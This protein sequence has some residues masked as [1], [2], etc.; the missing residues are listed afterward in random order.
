MLRWIAQFTDSS[1]I[2]ARAPIAVPLNLYLCVWIAMAFFASLGLAIGILASFGDEQRGVSIA[3][4]ATA[5]LAFLFFWPAYVGGALTFL[6]GDLFLPI[7]RHA[8]ELGL[9]FA[10]A[11]LVHLGLV[12]RLCA[13][14]SPPSR[15]TFGIFG[16]AAVFAYLL[17]VLSVDSLRRALPSKAWPILRTVAMSYIAFAFIL[18]FKKFPLSDFRPIIEYV[19]FAALSI[20]APLLRLAVWAQILRRKLRSSM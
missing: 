13:I 10:A 5:R 6:F 1:G 3:L 4:Q 11:L 17:V 8:R 20:V 14:G 15:E 7:R 9:A 18:D 2:K 12:V 19:P 16:L